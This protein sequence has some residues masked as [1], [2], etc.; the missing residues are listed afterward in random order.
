MG[1]SLH[2]GTAPQFCSP[3]G[4]PRS[5]QPPTRPQRLVKNASFVPL[6]SRGQPA[7]WFPT[8][9]RFPANYFPRGLIFLLRIKKGSSFEVFQLFFFSGSTGGAIIPFPALHIHLLVE[10]GKLDVP[11]HIRSAVRVVPEMTRLAFLH[12][13]G[14]KQN[15]TFTRP[16]ASPCPPIHLTPNIRFFKNIHLIADTHK[17][18]T[19]CF[20]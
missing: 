16:R 5:R 3:G 10:I 11:L 18:Y 7:C 13:S 15:R 9:F 12:L 6:V 20:V 8:S 14:S 17:K 19:A 2:K 1:H 4:L